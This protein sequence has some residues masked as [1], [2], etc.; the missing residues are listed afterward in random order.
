M[1]NYYEGIVKNLKRDAE[2]LS[3]GLKNILENNSGDINKYIGMTKALKETLSL[4]KEFDWQ[5][6][7]SQYETSE[8]DGTNKH[9]EV[10]IWEQNSQNEIRNHQ[11]FEVVKDLSKGRLSINAFIDGIT[12]RWNNMSDG[13]KHELAINLVGIKDETTFISMMNKD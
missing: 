4:I 8:S 2:S 1:E 13:E 9:F 6:K 12:S 11:H 7:Y 3:K 10:A 5:L